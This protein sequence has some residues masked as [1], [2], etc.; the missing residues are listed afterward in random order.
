MQV[1][2]KKMIIENTSGLGEKALTHK[3]KYNAFMGISILHKYFAPKRMKYFL[4]W[5][6][7]VFN[8]FTILL[9]DDPDIYNFMTFK[10]MDQ[11]TALKKARRISSEKEA[12]YQKLIEKYNLENV[13]VTKFQDFEKE[14][15]YTKYLTTIKRYYFEN[16]DF[17][18]DVR[19]LLFSITGKIDEYQRTHELTDEQVDQVIENS[20]INYLIEELATIIYFSELN[21]PIEVDPTEEFPTKRNLYVGKYPEIARELGLSKRGHIYTHPEGIYKNTF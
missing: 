10:K 4:K 9:I 21:H 19:E 11:L 16:S 7:K 6:S 1:F 12:S 2:D 8:K 15:L 13:S 17:H 3:G 14:T 20:L 18:E 5:G